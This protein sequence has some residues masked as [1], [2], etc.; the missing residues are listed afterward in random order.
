MKQ[1]V[2]GKGVYELRSSLCPC[3][4]HGDVLMSD[5]ARRRSSAFACFVPEITHGDL[6]FPQR[7][8]SSLCSLCDKSDD[9][10][11]IFFAGE[12]QNKDAQPDGC[13]QKAWWSGNMGPRTLVLRT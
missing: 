7:Y 11:G 2:V 13:V 1:E 4:I 5:G 3:Y 6:A 10:G 8:S 12:R 9:V